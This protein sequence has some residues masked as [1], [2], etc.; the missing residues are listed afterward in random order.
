MRLVRAVAVRY[1]DLGLPFEDLVQ[2]GAIG[3]LS[4]IDAFDAR[5]GAAFS[6]FAHLR[7]RNAVMRALT[8]S[9]RPVRLPKLL[10]E[11]RHLLSRAD[12][13]LLAAGRRPSIEAL[14]EETGLTVDE[15]V[16]ALT[17]PAATASL[18]APVRD[19]LTVEDLVAD[20]S[21]VDP[22]AELFEDERHRAVSAALGHLSPRH[23]GVITRYFGLA[24][25][26]ANL[27]QIGTELDVSAQRARAI[28]DDALHDLADEL[29]RELAPRMPRGRCPQ[30]GGSRARS[31][32]I[33]MPR[34]RR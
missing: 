7:V 10:V 25:D 30:R 8:T 11:R 4:A 12:E 14:S 19:G 21:A 20:P 5:H 13:R 15:V 24:G 29:E 18:D 6:T 1:R 22:E 17:A 3:L 26:E 9:G 33:T 28:R 16:E 23:Q 2:E 27:G 31:A 32:A 34:R